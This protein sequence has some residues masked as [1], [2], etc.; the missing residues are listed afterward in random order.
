MGT[1]RIQR[2][3][4]QYFFGSGRKIL[5]P[6]K[7]EV[8][9]L[10]GW[11]SPAYFSALRRARSLSV[12][13]VGFYEST[14]NSQRH[15]TG[16]IAWVRAL[17]FRRLDAVVV[18]GVA[19]ADALRKMGVKEDR[20][21]I[22]FNAVDGHAI[23]RGANRARSILSKESA[24]HKFIFIGQLIERKNP[25]GLL[26]A[27]NDISNLGDTLTVVGEGELEPELRDRCRADISLT[28]SIPYSEVPSKLAAHH[29]LVMP[30]HSEVWGLVANEALAAGLH[31]VVSQE[32]GVAPSI[33]A[34]SGVFVTPTSR[35]QLG[36]AHTSH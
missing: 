1:R 15:T 14:L 27:F 34:M 5:G 3:E 21:H 31:V 30:S 36:D 20:I 29:T 13:V 18:P 25:L 26:D 19:A 33:L 28:G 32:S 17:F 16:P 11:E 35:K 8:V 24:G 7:P 10:G 4:A 23:A 2:G 6:T 22:G 12:P 9:L